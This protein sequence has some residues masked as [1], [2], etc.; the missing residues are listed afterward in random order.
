MDLDTLR[1]QDDTVDRLT[2]YADELRR[3]GRSDVSDVRPGESPGSEYIVTGEDRVDVRPAEDGGY[4]WRC[5][6]GA[7]SRSDGTDR[8]VLLATAYTKGRHELPREWTPQPGL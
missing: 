2:L 3:R 6:S 7:V 4:L 8:G 1:D 5:Y